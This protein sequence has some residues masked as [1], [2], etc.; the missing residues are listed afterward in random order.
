MREWKIFLIHHSHT[1]IG[2]TDRQ[3]N[4]CLTHYGFL[5]QAIAACRASAEAAPDGK[6]GFR[7]QTENFWQIENFLK[8]ASPE[9]T[10]ALAEAV[11]NGG[12]GLSGSYLNLTELVD[13]DT[14]L[15][16]LK[17]A[18]TYAEGIGC[19]ACSAM[20][21]DINGYAWGTADIMAEAGMKNL[22]CALHSHHGM[23][24][25]GRNPSC[26]YWEGPAK[27]R[28][29]TF[30]G[31]HYHWGNVLGFCPD[32]AS[33]YFIDDEFY[34][35]MESGRI[36][37]TDRETTRKEELELAETRIRRYLQELEDCGYPFEIVP[38][39]VS[40]VY[41]DNAPPNPR[42]EERVRELNSLLAG[43]ASIRMSVLD[44]FFEALEAYRDQI[45]VFSGDFTDWWADGTGAAPDAV[46]LF[47]EG[48]RSLNIARELC[49][50]K[51]IPLPESAGEAETQAILFSEH[52][53]SYS[54]S[55]SDPYD[56]LVN[57]I[58]AQKAAY[59]AE[60]DTL[61]RRT[62][63]RVLTELGMKTDNAEGTQR[64]RI[65]N[66]S[67]RQAVLPVQIPV[68]GWE[69]IEGCTFDRSRPVAVRNIRTGEILPCQNHPTPR[70]F[71]VETA[72][73]LPAYGSM[74]VEVCYAL[75]KR[76]GLDH[77]PRF[78]ADSVTDIEN[79]PDSVIPTLIRTDDFT[80]RIS[81][82]KGVWS[83][84]ERRTGKELLDPAVPCGLFGTAYD[85]TPPSGASQVVTRRR[86][87][88]KRFSINTQRS[89]PRVRSVVIAENGEVYT[90][91]RIA[92]ELNG[93]NSCENELRFYK[94][95]PLIRADIRLHK[96]SVAGAESLYTALPFAGTGDTY[97]DKTGCILRPGI[98][99]LPGTCQEF[100][101]A[102]NGF[103]RRNGDTDV[104]VAF[105]DTPLTVFGLPE[106]ESVKL[107]DGNN[108]ELNGRPVWAW[109]MNNFWETNFNA[110][111]GG[112]H[113][114]RFD[115]MTAP[116][117]DPEIQMKRCGMMNEG[118][119]VFRI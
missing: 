10:E 4:V 106:A 73:E 107:C 59:A 14:L 52:T 91:V 20:T 63:N 42:I 69:R 44:E 99:Q 88:R 117:E 47:R 85:L 111:L 19:R 103:T 100:W 28:I 60:T 68:Q 57:A 26:F 32:G 86:M 23:F 74:D 77:I 95:F 39:M 96:Q 113:H 6:P 119:V 49:G 97:I 41:S 55:V 45:P 104:I 65:L 48:Q 3:E 31:E 24:P 15:H 61:G 79:A 90:S 37:R 29:L 36:M 46:S 83:V 109:I 64:Y 38:I 93:C 71:A 92:Y 87:G 2:Y 1:D 116:A 76:V 21:A 54:S 101:L 58:A 7:W 110:E 53:F 84:T 108:R 115:V 98:D 35:A 56:P 50:A 75:L 8:Y 78:G 81:R 105:R 16:V 67:D 22:F 30:V 11:R 118:F 70:G 17:R 51:K 5:K 13:R 27:N 33:S 66:P 72:V 12:I 25:M 62:L 112:F 94:H 89:M 114:F 43:T 18:E 102:G 40:G 34:R 80:V 9:E 82:E